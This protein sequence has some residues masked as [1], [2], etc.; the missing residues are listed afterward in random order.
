MQ[1]NLIIVFAQGGD[2]A[3]VMRQGQVGRP[4]RDPDTGM[5]VSQRIMMS[6]VTRGV[7]ADS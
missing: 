2:L 3:A 5:L 7:S 1:R 6:D 4:R